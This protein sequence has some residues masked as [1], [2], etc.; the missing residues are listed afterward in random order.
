[1]KVQG[2]VH[3]KLSL[4]TFASSTRAQLVFVNVLNMTPRFVRL[5]L[6]L[7]ICSSENFLGV[8]GRSVLTRKIL[9][10]LNTLFLYTVFCKV[11]PV[12]FEG[13]VDG[14][15]KALQRGAG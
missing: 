12:P 11:P 5:L 3:E 2:L 10:S 4:W 8:P 13:I 15:G 1:M 7:F 14:S 6:K 9:K